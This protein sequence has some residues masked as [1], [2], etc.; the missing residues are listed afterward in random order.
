MNNLVH[1]NDDDFHPW[2]T[3]TLHSLDIG[4]IM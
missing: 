1:L 3:Y 4:L 2:D